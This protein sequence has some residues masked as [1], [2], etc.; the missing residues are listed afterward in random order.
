MEQKQIQNINLFPRKN[1]L[2]R[3]LDKNDQSDQNNQKD[4]KKVK[5]TKM[6][7]MGGA[8]KCPGNE[9]DY[10]REHT[11]ATECNFHLKCGLQYF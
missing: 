1:L 10:I 5:I 8:M 2:K 11:N 9:V 7:R 3:R 4:K 6:T